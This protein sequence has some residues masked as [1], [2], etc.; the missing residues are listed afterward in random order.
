MTTP[1]PTIALFDPS[2]TEDVVALWELCFDGDPGR[3]EPRAY[4]AQKIAYQPQFFLVA[5]VN[6]RVVG[7]IVGGYDGVRGWMYH[8]ATHPDARRR[9]I[10]TR[11]V[12]DLEQR[13][14]AVGCVKL[15]L[16]I[17][18]ENSQLA[19]FYASLGYAEEPRI[20]LGKVLNPS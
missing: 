20:S 16:Q 19:D 15:N 5:I 18:S 7:T 3:N 2:H 11:L 12:R 13:L 6:Q 9:K 8:L 10:A 4:I 1:T 17:R 14:K